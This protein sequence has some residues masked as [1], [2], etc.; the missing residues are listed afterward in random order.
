MIDVSKVE[1]F[2]SWDGWREGDD[3]KKS[4][5]VVRAA[6][7]DA[8]AEERDGLLKQLERI[9]GLAGLGVSSNGL[10]DDV[11]CFLATGD[12]RPAAQQKEGE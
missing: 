7:Y 5:E 10:A 9:V 1:R 8:L 6:D 12:P 4:N 11:T 3:P 2:K